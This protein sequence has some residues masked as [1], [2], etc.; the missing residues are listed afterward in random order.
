MGCNKNEK[1]ITLPSGEEFP[2]RLKNQRNPKSLMKIIGKMGGNLGDGRI[3]SFLTPPKKSPLKY[4]IPNKYP[5]TKRVY[6]IDYSGHRTIFP[7]N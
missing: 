7:T 5:P 1:K 2:K 3:P 4:D 6:G